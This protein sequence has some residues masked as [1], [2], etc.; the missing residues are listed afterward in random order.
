[1]YATVQEVN[2]RDLH[3]KFHIQ[4]LLN[5]YG[6]Y[7]SQV[8]VF[9]CV[10]MQETSSYRISVSSPKDCEKKSISK[11]DYF[12]GINTNSGDS[13]YVDF[14]LEGEAKGWVAIGFSDTPSMVHST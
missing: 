4:L 5:N 10:F 9:Y 11:C 2:T 8:G 7:Y 6:N 13:S 1:M 12:F 3:K 14:T